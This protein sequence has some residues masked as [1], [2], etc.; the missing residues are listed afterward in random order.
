MPSTIRPTVTV[1][2]AACLLMAAL[3]TTATAQPQGHIRDRL[4]VGYFYGTF[5]QEPNIGVLVGGRAEE[6]CLDNPADPFNAEPGSAPLRVFPNDD[7]SVVLKVNDTG[8]P[9]HLYHQHDVV[10]PEWIAQVCADFFAG[11]PAPEPL[12]SGTALL[13]VRLGIDGDVVDVF[14]SVNG[15]ASGPDGTVYKVR[16]WADLVVV[17]GV[18]QGDPTDFV[19][20]EITE[21][22]R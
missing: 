20:T 6:F 18:P 2:L 19:G 14:N 22:R 16:A 3:A 8:Q 17:D 15:T 5:D 21:I 1:L 4:D 9:I 10:G 12:A 11:A 7:G 13:K